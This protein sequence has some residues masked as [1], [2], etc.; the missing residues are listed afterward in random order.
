MYFKIERERERLREREREWERERAYTEL[1]PPL[2]E[3]GRKDL[4][5]YMK[6]LNFATFWNNRLS[7]W[8]W[9]NHILTPG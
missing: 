2:M 5:I 7:M 4:N 1:I 9:W 3:I 8:K 6:I